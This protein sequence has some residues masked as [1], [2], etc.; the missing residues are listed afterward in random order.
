MISATVNDHLTISSKSTGSLLHSYAEICALLTAAIALVVLVGWSM[1]TPILTQ[2]VPGAASMK[3]NTAV[4][5]L[6]LA[7]SVLGCAHTD[8]P[9]SGT[10]RLRKLPGLLLDGPAMLVALVTALT[11][12]QYIFR[13]DFGIDTLLLRVTGP[14]AHPTRM[15]PITAVALLLLST[16]I[17]TRRYTFQK[18]ICPAE[19]LALL[20]GA[21]ALIAT[22]GYVYGI[23]AR[24]AI[25]IYTSM[26]I[27][28]AI[29]LLLLTTAVLCS[30]HRFAVFRG[31]SHRHARG[32][33]IRRLIP[34]AILVPPVL[35]WLRLQGQI[36]SWYSTEFGLAIHVCMHVVVFS[37]LIWVTARRVE[38]IDQE[39][40]NV[41]QQLHDQVRRLR[42]LSNLSGAMASRQ[43]LPSVY[44]VTTSSVRSELPVRLCAV[45]DVLH[46]D[47]DLRVIS[48]SAA[49]AIAL[50]SGQRLS[51]ASAVL[52]LL[53]DDS[54]RYVPDTE[55]QPGDFSW[56][57]FGGGLGSAVIAPLRKDGRIHG[58]LLAARGER[59]AFEEGDIQFIQQLSDNLSMAIAQSTMQASLQH[60]YDEIKLAQSALMQQERLRALSEMSSGVAHDFN[61]AIAP[62]AL[63]T[64]LLLE[65]EPGLSPLARSTLTSIQQSVKTAA[66]TVARMREFSRPTPPNVAWTTVDL[67]AMIHEVLDLTR[68]MWRDQAMSRGVRIAV[69]LELTDQPLPVHCIPQELNGALTNLVINAIDA[70][71][72]GGT[73]TFRTRNHR[74][75]ASLDIS[76]TGLGMSTEVQQQC[77]EPY[78]T[79]KGERGTGLGL[80]MVY[81]TVQRHDGSVQVRSEI[82]SGTTFTLQFATSNLV[83]G[84]T[85]TPADSHVESKRLLVIEDDPMLRI[86]LTEVLEADGHRVATA[87]DG[88][89]GLATFTEA[90]RHQQPFDLVLT[91]YGMPRMD[92]RALASAV[93]QASPR[94]PV[95]LLTGWARRMLDDCEIPPEV[96]QTLSKPPTLPE[97]RAAIAAATQHR[98][99]AAAS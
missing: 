76:D 23:G 5:L 21:C 18:H 93:K 88:I 49:D 24:Y 71:P 64:Q 28:T 48:V 38:A 40:M 65:K 62:I 54:V 70:M 72:N 52:T 30:N 92:G 89:E 75:I 32:T 77:F 53:A 16:S 47:D 27:P 69:K 4:S 39:R 8:L 42:L 11:L 63:C 43:S 82:G 95:I 56:Q 97:I 7:L 19:Y 85:T 6:L 68:P 58:L 36:N 90:M 37:C 45:C 51:G 57:L 26:A 81:G 12:A 55:S 9:K 33:L 44:D 98:V 29:C 60:A 78:F 96:D 22:L 2:L 86:T 79:T 80:A 74:G 46:A 83:A 67:N 94:T 87:E 66:D 99:D 91:D 41:Q 31:V 73:L 10:T 13:I 14:S 17:V 1:D 34:A 59:R 35:G 50:V 25:Q 3:P 84:P 15:A 20:A 61:N